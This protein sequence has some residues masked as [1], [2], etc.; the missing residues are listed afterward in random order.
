MVCNIALQLGRCDAAP[1]TSDPSDPSQP[2]VTSGPAVTVAQWVETVRT[3]LITDWIAAAESNAKA[4]VDSVAAR[5]AY[6]ANPPPET[7][8][9]AP[10][11]AKGGKSKLPEP[12]PQPTGP[13]PI[14]ELDTAL[15]QGVRVFEA[16]KFAFVPRDNLDHV[17]A[18]IFAKNHPLSK[19]A[20]ASDEAASHTPEV[21]ST[22]WSIFGDVDANL[23]TVEFR[24]RFLWLAQLDFTLASALV[25]LATFAA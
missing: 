23:V 11:A 9:P 21:L 10:A 17:V 4:A 19:D 12:P 14:I 18:S 20:S 2:V 7:P 22:A 15:Q 13:P 3:T 8:V 5:E 1:I 25:S 6:L 24:R 16:L